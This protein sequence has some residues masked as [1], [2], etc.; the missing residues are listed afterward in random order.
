MGLSSSQARLLSLTGRMHDIE[1]KAQHLEAQKL[2]MANESAH[3]YKEYENALNKTKIQVKQLASDGS[4]TY[5]DATYNSMK[6]LGYTMKFQDDYKPIISAAT[7]SNLKVAGNNRDYFIA[8]ESG[9]VTTTNT[10]VNGVTEIYTADQLKNMSSSGNY[11]L[12][13]DI[14]MTGI[15]WTSKT[16]SGNLDGNGHTIR[17]LNKALF[18]TMSGTVS[19]LNINGDVTSRSILTNILDNGTVENVTISGSIN[20]TSDGVGSLAGLIQGNSTVNNC[21]SS[22]NVTSSNV[23]VG[24]LI[25]Q[26][27]NGSTLTATN[28]NATGNVTGLANVGG[29]IAGVTYGGNCDI[30]NC[31]ASGNVY[32]TINTS[33]DSTSSTGGFI[34]GGYGGVISNCES[35]GN[36]SAEGHVIGGFV[37]N[38]G[39]DAGSNS[40]LTIQNC[41]SYGNVIGNINNNMIHEQEKNYVLAGGFASAVNGGTIKDCNAFGTTSSG[42]PTKKTTTFASHNMSGIDNIGKII[43]GYAAPNPPQTFTSND[44]APTKLVEVS[45]ATTPNNNVITVTPPTVKTTETVNDTTGAGKTFDDINKYG[46]YILEG[47]ANDPVGKYGDDSNWFTTMVNEGLLFLLKN[48]N[49][50]NEYQVNVATDTSLQE[51]TDDIDL[52]KAEAKYEADMRKIN[53]KD[54]KF[55]T[56]IAALESERNAISTE[57]DTLKSVA[58]DNVDRTFK[59]FS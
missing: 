57:M 58:K 8:L 2:Q 37:G 20:T 33:T 29:F 41:N 13:S 14:D 19:N 11:R 12:M 22:A 56:D 27:R 39:A 1:Y 30:S 46:G 28:C 43:N 45:E 52:K 15:N 25:G 44:N 38:A 48:D 18:S 40:Q 26:V 55:D 6:S 51:V 23:W 16:F 9:R 31:S 34:G 53:A 32:A 3:V 10:K 42:D 5:I 24:G 49:E 7:E 36:V 47:T 4:T 17:G 35:K 54:K 59:L 50:G 21:S